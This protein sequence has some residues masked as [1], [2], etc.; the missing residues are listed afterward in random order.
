MSYLRLLKS[1]LSRRRSSETGDDSRSD[2]SSP[3]LSSMAGQG[4]A[5]PPARDKP[6]LARP[7]RSIASLWIETAVVLILAVVPYFFYALMWST[8]S[9]SQTRLTLEY[10]TPASKC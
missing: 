9:L 4:A 8:P 6:V 1:W 3:P 10:I 7:V 5:L 2:G